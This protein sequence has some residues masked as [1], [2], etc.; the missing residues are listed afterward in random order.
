[1]NSEFNDRRKQ[2]IDSLRKSTLTTHLTKFSEHHSPKSAYLCDSLKVQ[3]DK[4]KQNSN[5]LMKTLQE[6]Q[7]NQY[8]ITN[9]KFNKIGKSRFSLMNVS[10][11]FITFIFS[12]KINIA[13]NA[14]R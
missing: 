10:V 8:F 4:I 5:I 7:S 12:V 11:F 1:M 9:L 3:H 14:K 13:Y 6:E 2:K